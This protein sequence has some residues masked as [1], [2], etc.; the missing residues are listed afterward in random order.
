M[1]VITAGTGDIVTIAVPPDPNAHKFMG[2]FEAARRTDSGRYAL[3]ADQA[4]NFAKFALL[5]SWQVTDQREQANHEALGPLPECVHCGQPAKRFDDHEKRT[6]HQP[7][8][9]CPDCGAPW[10][11][12]IVKVVEQDLHATQ[13]CQACGHTQLGAFPRCSNCGAELAPPEPLAVP[14]RPNLPDPVPVAETVWDTLE[15]IHERQARATQEPWQPLITTE[16]TP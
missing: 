10:E 3:P 13:T 1:F 2:R 8:K 11:S 15:Q 14:Q 6:P 16:G 4:D 9:F 12:R 5:A 7:P